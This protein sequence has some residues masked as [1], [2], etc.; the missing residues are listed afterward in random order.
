VLYTDEGAGE[1]RTF[2]TRLEC[3]STL[4]LK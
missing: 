3:G 2:F 4:Q 1:P